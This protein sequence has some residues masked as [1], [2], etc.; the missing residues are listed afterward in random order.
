MYRYGPLA[1]VWR[2][3]IAFGLAL[4]GLAAIGTVLTLNPLLLVAAL[5]L[6]GPACFFGVVLVVRV[7]G[8]PD[9]T[10]RIDTLMFVRRRISAGRVGRPTVRVKYRTLYAD[11]TAPRVWVP[12]KGGLPLYVD[13]LGDIRDREAFFAAIHLRADELR[14]AE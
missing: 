3:C 11:L 7:E 9:G 4:G 6:L 13:L 10:L 5:A 12:V 8:E 1:W 2:G 14:R